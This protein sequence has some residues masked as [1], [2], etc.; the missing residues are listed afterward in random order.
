MIAKYFAMCEMKVP[1]ALVVTHASALVAGQRLVNGEGVYKGFEIVCSSFF[2][3]THFFRRFT[4]IL[5]IQSYEKTKSRLAFCNDCYVTRR[6][7]G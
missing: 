1:L 4:K 7:E 5:R 3:I 6:F 2:F